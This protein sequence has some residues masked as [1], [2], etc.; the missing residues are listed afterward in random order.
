VARVTVQGCLQRVSNHF[1]LVILA[2]RRARQIEGGAVP[3]VISTNKAAVTALR[4]VDAGKVAFGENVRDVI[5]EFI[6]E[7]GTVDRASKAGTARRRWA[8]V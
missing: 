1:A 7:R 3:L 8:R 2:A 4:E 5:Q 6:T